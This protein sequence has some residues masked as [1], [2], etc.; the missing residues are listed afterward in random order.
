MAEALSQIES[1]LQ[2]LNGAPAPDE[3]PGG[4]G[5]V[6]FVA[7][8]PF[9]AKDVLARVISVWKIIDQVALSDWPTVEQWNMKLPEWFT[10]ACTSPMTQQQADAWLAGWKRLTPVEQARA[11][12]EKKWSLENWLYWMKPEDRQWFWWDAK[13]LEDCDHIIV[14]VEVDAWPFPW[15]SLRWL[16]KVAGASTLEPEPADGIEH[17]SQT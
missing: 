11:E 4:V 16:F 9:G 7:R 12:S 14:A 3:K 1:E 5:T 8:C 13:A 2:R 17:S 15:G 10:S 6:S